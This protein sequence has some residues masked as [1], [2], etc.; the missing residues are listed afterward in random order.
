MSLVN[1]RILPSTPRHVL[2]LA[3]GLVLALSGCS[4]PGQDSQPVLAAYDSGFETETQFRT[5][6]DFIRA[7]D[8]EEKWRQIGWI[9]SL[10]DAV[11]M[12]NEKRKPIF[13][14]AMNG[15]P[16]GCV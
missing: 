9:P 4:A 5:M 1:I 6:F 13:V 11:E 12:A 15:D 8:S 16:L 10:W 14:W 3:L 7:T 2:T